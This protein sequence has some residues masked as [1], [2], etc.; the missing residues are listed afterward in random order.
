[1]VLEVDRDNPNSKITDFLSRS[2]DLIEEMEH[3]EHYSK[4]WLFSF[5]S[6]QLDLLKDLSFVIAIMINMLLLFFY[7]ENPSSGEDVGANHSE[8]ENLI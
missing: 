8:I 3:L 7:E 6:K 4:G 5:F 1:M 2:E